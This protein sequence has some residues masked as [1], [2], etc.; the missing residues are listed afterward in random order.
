M[1]K[2]MTSA[3]TGMPLPAPFLNAFRDAIERLADGPTETGLQ[4]SALATRAV[5][6]NP[7]LA[8]RVRSFS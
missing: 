6:P 1:T 5:W 8:S 3:M 7:S 2:T 4:M